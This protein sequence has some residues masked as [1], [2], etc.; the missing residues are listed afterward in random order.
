[1][2]RNNAR[3]GRKLVSECRLISKRVTKALH[4][5]KLLEIRILRFP[6]SGPS[7]KIRFG[8]LGISV[9]F[10]GNMELKRNRYILLHNT[11]E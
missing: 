6:K 3:G 5:R 2:Y 4:F 10:S 11:L 9:L 1:M 8:F 7:V